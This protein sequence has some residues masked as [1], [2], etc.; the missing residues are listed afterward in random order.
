MERQKSGWI[1]LSGVCFKYLFVCWTIQSLFALIVQGILLCLQIFI[2]LAWAQRQ[3][4]VVSWDWQSHR[5]SDVRWGQHTL[6]FK[7]TRIYYFCFTNSTSK[8][9]TG[10]VFWLFKLNKYK[11][12][13]WHLASFYLWLVLHLRSRAH[14]S[15]P[16]DTHHALTGLPHTSLP[17]HSLSLLRSSMT[18]PTRRRT[19]RTSWPVLMSSWM[20]WSCCLL[21][22]GTR[23]SG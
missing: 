16:G 13:I 8:K 5:H 22:S 14:R 4:Q 18:L 10:P 11:T 19:D 23:P 6:S 21:E 1:I 12:W 7:Y 9:K 15:L 17:C 2:H 3:G 20:R